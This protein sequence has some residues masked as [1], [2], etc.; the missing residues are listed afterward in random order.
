MK[1]HER[2]AT[3]AVM[4]VIRGGYDHQQALARVGQCMALAADDAVG[5]IVPAHAL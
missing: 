4:Q 5:G 1:P 3:V 2:D